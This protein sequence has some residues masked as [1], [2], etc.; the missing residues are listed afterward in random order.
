MGREQQHAKLWVSDDNHVSEVVWWNCPLI[1]SLPS[2]GRRLPEAQETGKS[3]DLKLPSGRFD[4]AFAPE[5][6]EY[7]GSR[8]VQ[9]KLLDWH[10]T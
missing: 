1:P 4:L 9:L 2:D 5:I 3:E 7:N 8:S 10:P 6:N